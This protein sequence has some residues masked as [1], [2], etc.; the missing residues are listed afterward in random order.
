M[1]DSVDIY[2]KALIRVILD[3]EEY[4]AYNCVKAKLSGM[5]D[6]KKQINEF[7]MES[8]RLQKYGDEQTLFE[9]I[10]AFRHEYDEFR[11]NTL[12]DEYLRCE[13]AVCR[14]MQKVAN[15]IA[16]SVDLELDDML[17]QLRG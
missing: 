17:P 15:R 13:L 8:F 1:Q 6:L 3:S 14:M 9:Q 11:K 4:R 2:T 10:E 12:V 7:R 16:D 5:P